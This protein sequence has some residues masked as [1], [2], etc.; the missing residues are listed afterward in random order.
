MAVIDFFDRGWR[1]NPHGIAYIQDER[2][3]SF[4]EVGE[5]SWRVANG[6][7][8]AGFAKEAK[9]AVWADND[10]TAWTCMLGM[11]RAGMTLIPVNGRNAP[12]ENQF[13]L[14]FFD[15]ETLFFQK[16]FASTI[17]ALRSS[18]PKVRF[19]VCIDAE[20][21]W[22]PSL[23]KWTEDHPSTAVRIDYY[24][25][26]VVTLAGTGGTTG[27]PKG[28]MN[29]NRAYQT[30]F[31]QFMMAFPYGTERPVNLAAAPMTHTAGML[32]LP[33]TARGGTVVVL[34]KPDP[35]LL[36][37]AIERYRVTEFFLPPTVIYRLLDIPGIEKRDFSSLKYFLYGAAPMSV[38]KL[39]RAIEVFGPVMA[40][41][42]GQ[43]E[44][45]SSIS[46]LTPAEHFVAGRIAPD[47]RL[48][49]VGRPNPLIRVEIL[50]KGGQVLPQGKSGEICVRGDLLMK[51]YY[52][53]PDKTAETIV[54]GWLHTGDI[55][56]L[57]AD[58]YLHIT[59]RTKDMI[60]SGGFNVYPS[61]VEQVIW[62]HPAVQDCA[63]IGVPDEKWGE[64][65]KA[66]VEL[67][68]GQSVS[69]EE[70]IALCK[71]RLGSVRTPKS[72]DFVAA[73]PR[74]TVGK[75]LKKDLRE[76]YWQG[77]QRRI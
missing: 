10:V 41:A 28:V 55:G 17:E 1:I 23:A 73:L 3:Y 35:A 19:W 29:T 34:T 38:E 44:A 5:L 21:P 52:K 2:N 69:A 30:F 39:K 22:A 53:A 49:S 65:V 70:L 7:F 66:V 4:Q 36:L 68:V 63:V 25:D 6:L 74:S 18:L 12:A 56:H 13:I 75:V 54:D 43:T 60:I 76:Q 11:W 71:E 16:A 50:G 45:P 9:A 14:D 62:S 24:M 51:G 77:Q 42:Y 72:V 31:A 58:G 8:A 40:G 47:D 67:N 48:S 57:D 27:A 32:S 64:A 15:C 37:E 46:Y 20:L 26:D 59:D 33:C 61:E